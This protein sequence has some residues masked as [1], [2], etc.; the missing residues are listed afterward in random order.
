MNYQLQIIYIKNDNKVRHM[1]FIADIDECMLKTVVCDNICTN[2]IGSYKCS[3][4]SGRLWHDGI[5]CLGKSLCVLLD[6]RACC[7]YK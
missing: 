7:L 2:T 5:Q 4:R 1:M 3:C 6:D